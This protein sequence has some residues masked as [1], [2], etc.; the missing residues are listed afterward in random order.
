MWWVELQG[1]GMDAEAAQAESR[2][3]S[4]FGNNG[5]GDDEVELSVAVLVNPFLSDAWDCP[6]I[7]SLSTS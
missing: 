3:G 5:G 6:L 4:L 2:R 7:A 1:V